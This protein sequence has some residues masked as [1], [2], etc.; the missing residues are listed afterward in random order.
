MDGDGAKD[1]IANHTIDGK[2]PYTPTVFI[3]GSD[4]QPVEYTG[5]YLSGPLDK[6]ICNYCDGHGF[7]GGQALSDSIDTIK[8]TDEA[9]VK[10]KLES[11]KAPKAPEM[12]IKEGDQTSLFEGVANLKL[13]RS[14]ANSALKGEYDITDNHLIASKQYSKAPHGIAHGQ[15]GYVPRQSFGAAFGGYQSGQVYG[16]SHYARDASG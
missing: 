5:E 16:A 1:I 15:Y 4:K 12:G 2:V 8:I 9:V 3:Y 10:A 6:Y 11:P 13:L 14:Q 7:G